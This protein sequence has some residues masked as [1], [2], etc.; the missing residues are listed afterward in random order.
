MD[1]WCWRLRGLTHTRGDDDRPW[2]AGTK[3]CAARVNSSRTDVRIVV[4]DLF[5]TGQYR[6]KNG[7]SKAEVHVVYPG[8]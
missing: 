6:I 2:R 5:I 8:R 3:E 4:Y 1:G 7:R